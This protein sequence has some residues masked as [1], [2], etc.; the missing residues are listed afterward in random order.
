MKAK[1]DN[2]FT[3]TLICCALVVTFLVARHEGM[4][5]MIGILPPGPDTRPFFVPDPDPL[6]DMGSPLGAT[7]PELLVVE[8]SDFQCAFCAQ[9]W[10]VMKMLRERY[11]ERIGILYRHLPPPRNENSR[12]AALAAECANEQARFESFHDVLFA[13]QS[14]IGT[15]TWTEFAVEAGVP[16]VEAFDQ[17]VAEGRYAER[18]NQDMA[19]AQQAG[20]ASTPSFVIAGRLFVGAGR[21]SEMDS[22]IADQLDVTRDE[23]GATGVSSR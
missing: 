17:C 6:D 1:L 11:N 23:P 20:I 22:W 13:Q 16:D 21:V 19:A 2:V 12:T 18:I 15:K 7:S 14:L 9:M 3:G 5:T 4:L 8:F 10:P